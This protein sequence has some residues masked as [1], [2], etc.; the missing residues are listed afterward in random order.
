MQYKEPASVLFALC[1]FGSLFFVFPNTSFGENDRPSCTCEFVC[2]MN[3]SD[4]C[5]GYHCTQ[6][7]G[8]PVGD[9]LRTAMTPCPATTTVTQGNTQVTGALD[10]DFNPIGPLDNK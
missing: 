9:P 2:T 3:Q 5:N 7:M 8:A 10:S 1:V 4:F 6:I